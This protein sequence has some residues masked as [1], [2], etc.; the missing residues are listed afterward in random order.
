MKHLKLFEGFDK[1]DYYQE[2]NQDDIDHAD[3]ISF[4]K[5]DLDILCHDYGFNYSRFGDGSERIYK[6]SKSVGEP[7]SFTV[8][9]YQLPDEYFILE[10]YCGGYPIEVFFYKCDQVEGVIKLLEDKGWV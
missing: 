6:Q 7:N 3:C 10:A 9:V 8:Y 2:I 4:S 5:G 1:S